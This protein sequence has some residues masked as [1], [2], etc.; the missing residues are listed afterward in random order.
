MM[1]ERDQLDLRFKITKGTSRMIVYKAIE[2]NYREGFCFKKNCNFGPDLRHKGIFL[3]D[4]KDLSICV[5]GSQYNFAAFQDPFQVSLISDDLG[6]NLRC[7][8]ILL[9]CQLIQNIRKYMKRGDC[10]FDI[11]MGSFCLFILLKRL[12]SKYEMKY[13]KSCGRNCNLIILNISN[14]KVLFHSNCSMKRGFGQGMCQQ[15]H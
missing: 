8:L 14:S 9:R 1:K 7:F 12:Y 6:W 10:I 15:R 5:S 13:L 3:Q 11:L 4:S 2:E